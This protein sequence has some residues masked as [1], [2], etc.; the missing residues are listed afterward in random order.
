MSCCLQCWFKAF[1]HLWKVIQEAGWG[2]ESCAVWTGDQNLLQ[3]HHVVIWLLSFIY[4]YCKFISFRLSEV[5]SCRNFLPEELGILAT[6]QNAFHHLA[7]SSHH[8]GF[9]ARQVLDIWPF[10]INTKLVCVVVS[11][12]FGVSPYSFSFLLYIN[13]FIGHRSDHSL[14][15]SVTHWLTDSQTCWRLNELT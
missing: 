4:A 14:R 2:C 3:H 7:A 8:H 15:M 5:S 11:R 6:W 1:P 10:D 13:I 9:S 12:S